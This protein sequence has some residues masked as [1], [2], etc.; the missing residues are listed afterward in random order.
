[1][2]N[3][4]LKLATCL[5]FVLVTSSLFAQNKNVPQLGS[6]PVKEVVKAMTLEEKVSM[7]VGTGMNFPGL[8]PDM[9]GPVVGQTENKVPGSAGTTI[10]I[11]RLG[12]P[13]IVLADG[14]AGLRIA[15]YRG[16]DSSVS[17]FC[18][19]FPIATL[20]ASSWDVD[21]V[22][23][24]GSAMGNEV[25]EYGVDILLA[26]A[27]NNH[28]NPLGGRNFEYYSE[29]PLINGKM[30]AAMV[31]GVQS[32]GVGTSIKHFAAN[33]HEWNRNTINVIVGQ[34]PLREIYL[35][36]FQLALKES[37]PWTVMSSYN[38]INGTYTSERHDLLTTVLRDEWGFKGFVM[39][40]WF[41]GSDAVAQMKAGNDL[42]MP[43]TAKQQKAILEAVQNHT[44]D[45]K[46][47]DQNV[48]RLLTIVLQT[49]SFKKYK[50]SNKP[51]L[52]GNAQIA[53]MAAAEGMVLLKNEGAVLPLP[54][55][56]K[57]AVF[58]NA[59]YDMV[60]GGT[61]SGDVNEAYTVSLIDGL[62]EAGLSPDESLSMPYHTYISEQKAKRPK[63]RNFFLLPPPIEEYN[64]PADIIAKMAEATDVAMVTIGR[65]SGEFA[66]RKLENDYYLSAIEKELLKN[67]SDAFHAKGKK[68]V[69]LLNVGGVIEV[70]SWR[71]G[72][73]AI[74]LT[75]QPG[76]EAGNAIAD[77]VSGKVTPSGKLATTFPMDY[78]DVSSAQ[79]FPG[80]T[81]EG[82]D[83]NNRSFFIN[84]KAAEVVY[85]E[86]IYTGY[87][88]YNTFNVKPAYEFGYG[89][90]YTDFKYGD[91]QL[92]APDQKG[93][94]NATV[95]VTDNGKLPGK[96]VVQL[97]I[98]APSKSL[99]KPAAELKAFAKTALLKP[100]QS[101]K[102]TFTIRADDLASFH[103]NASAWIAEAGNYKVAIGASS[104]DIKQTA[105]LA[106]SK[107]VV[108]EKVHKV[109]EPEKPINELKTA[110]K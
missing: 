54:H 92:S 8:S 86:G 3:P 64:V 42:L 71:D 44:L 38:K 89:L 83:P 27:L 56:A 94:F 68:V 58:G 90:S 110:S 73:D 103:P 22:K 13:S 14:P 49:P 47:L 93:Q 10:A 91:L 98:T 85:E 95:T 57:V 46:V 63:T 11:S 35:R 29:D 34:R 99:D 31:N 6:S 19:A 101:Q 75:W 106:L 55:A 39:T 7:V 107:D 48:E 45:E 40:D 33:N 88:Y 65:N 59:T 5:L 4:N 17:Y 69:V 52:R 21:L 100:G 104:K 24:V 1:M 25:K 97:Y 79:N 61:G 30:T 60:T 82:P 9:Q 102:L 84:D 96:E 74:L 32:Q 23:K 66:D 105:S 77:I 28:R 50:Y 78:K 80:K 43:G 2:K 67:I 41:G 20:L 87:R 36:G 81:L 109:L 37:K 16:K 15:P 18:T 12:I 26:P 53:R 62:K 70:A 72:V 76:Q 51:D 108:V